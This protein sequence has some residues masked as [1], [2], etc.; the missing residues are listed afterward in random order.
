MVGRVCLTGVIEIEIG[1]KGEVAEDTVV[2][3]QTTSSSHTTKGT[4]MNVR[5]T[6]P[7]ATGPLKKGL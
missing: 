5:L 1:I 6:K 3:D 2:E 7:R 4:K